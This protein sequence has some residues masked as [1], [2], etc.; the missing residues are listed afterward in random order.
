VLLFGPTDPDVWRPAN[1]Q[2][3]ILRAEE[4]ELGGLEVA[5]VLG[6]ALSQA[7]T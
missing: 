6:A 5:E 1:A 7:Q 3:T 4:G 2:V